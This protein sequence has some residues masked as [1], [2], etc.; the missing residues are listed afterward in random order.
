M[1]LLTYSKAA[2][3]GPTG[4]TQPTAEKTDSLRRVVQPFS[5]QALP[6]SPVNHIVESTIIEGVDDWLVALPA[7]IRS[8]SG[9]AA[10]PSDFDLLKGLST[11]AVMDWLN[12]D[13]LERHV[14]QLYTTAV[15]PIAL[16]SCTEQA[17]AP[18]EALERDFIKAIEIFDLA[19][20]PVTVMWKDA[21]V[22]RLDASMD[23]EGMAALDEKLSSFGLG[24]LRSKASCAW[25]LCQWVDARFKLVKVWEGSDSSFSAEACAALDAFGK[26]QGAL[27]TWLGANAD[28]LHDIGCPSEL[29]KT[30]IK[31]DLIVRP[32]V[33]WGSSALAATNSDIDVAVER[34]CSGIAK[35]CVPTAALMGATVLVDKEL[36]ARI[37]SAAKT[38]QF[39][40]V[41]GLE[42]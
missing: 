18:L 1:W 5:W 35:E 16:Q 23:A 28:R 25:R 37:K 32:A 40:K 39:V 21:A 42:R 7:V 4:Q 17:R 41:W 11:S 24:N 30:E 6:R 19:P 38:G 27:A 31:F 33:K 22:G 8:N 9:V 2:T 3:S 29:F 15:K 12:A 26:A 20:Q 36:Q 14:V 13:D 10:E 34:A